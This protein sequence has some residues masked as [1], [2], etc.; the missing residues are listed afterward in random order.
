MGNDGQ[1]LRDAITAHENLIAD[2]RVKLSPVDRKM[3]DLRLASIQL[4][5]VKQ[6]ESG[7]ANTPESPDQ[8][9]AENRRLL[10]VQRYLGEAS[11]IHFFHALESSFGQQPGSKQQDGP[12][13]QEQVDS[14]EQECIRP[15]SPEQNQGFFPQRTVADNLVNIYFST[16]HI[17]YPFISEPDF[18][19]TYENFWQSD[20]LEGFR[21]PW[22]SML[23]TI[24][25]LGSCYERVAEADDGAASNP[26]SSRQDVRY[27]DHAVAISQKQTSKRTAEYV[28]ALLTQCFYLLATCQTDRCWI[29]LG[30]AARIAQSIGLH[31]EEGSSDDDLTDPEGHKK[32]HQQGWVGDYFIAMIKFSGILGRVFHRLYGPKRSDDGV[33]ILSNIDLSDT[34]LLQWRSSLRRELRF[35]LS[36][37]FESSKVFRNQRNMLAVKF[38][39]LR[40]L[41]HRPLLS[42]AKVMA[43]SPNHLAWHQAEHHRISMSKR[44]CVMAAQQTAKLLH[45]LENKKSLIYGFPWWQ[46]ISCL[47]CASSILLVASICVDLNSKTEVEV[48]EDID[49]LAVDEDA[50]VCLQ[51]FQA[52]SSNSNAARLAR[53]MMQRLKKTRTIAYGKM[54]NSLSTASMPAAES[55]IEGVNGDLIAASPSDASMLSQLD[56]GGLSQ[57]SIDLMFQTMPYEVSEPVMCW[58]PTVNSDHQQ[59]KFLW[60]STSPMALSISLYHDEGKQFTPGSLVPGVVKF[61]NYEDQIIESL[62][63]D[64]RGHSNVFLNQNYGDM[65]IPRED[66]GS[67][68]YLFSRHLDLCSGNVVHQKGTHVWPFAFRIPFFAAPRIVSPGS[69]DF[70]RP[71]HPWRGDFALERDRP[72]PLPPS[73]Q[74]KGKFVCNVR[75][76]LDAALAHRRLTAT[77]S[78][79]V[80]SSRSVPV[81]SLEMAPRNSPGGDWVYMTHRQPLRCPRPKLSRR[82]FRRR[83]SNFRQKDQPSEPEAKLCFSVL[84]PKE[85]EVKERQALSV[86]IACTMEH[87]SGLEALKPQMPAQVSDLVVHSFKLSLL[88]HTHVRTGCQTSSS[89]RKIL[90][91]KGACIVPISRTSTSASTGAANSPYS[92]VNL[93]DVVDLSLTRHTL[94][95]DFSTYNIARFHSLEVRFCLIYAGKKNKFTLRN[96]PIRVVPQSGGE[97]ERRLSEG[98][99]ADDEYGCDLAGLQ[100]RG[101]RGSTGRSEYNALGLRSDE[102]D[103]LC[104]G[105]P[106]PAYTV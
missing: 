79:E 105:S 12:A 10:P 106:P 89:T 11:D 63:I 60:F 42:P 38:Y 58:C 51:V 83:F 66:A 4:P 62:K 93:S 69:K 27:F 21:G 74:A 53:D 70:Y 7:A 94:A 44:K 17:A 96:V 1:K 90:T 91:R 8:L 35:D 49:W 88:Q 81:Q 64:F 104:L 55:R 14:Y 68:A 39:N 29:T 34:E 47:I 85:I 67:R 3:I 36:H 97:L 45:N 87:S 19:A 101:Y 72:H 103:D 30:K 82:L 43:S 2:L 23:L 13:S 32:S 6:V 26:H 99:E 86:P 71:T 102:N 65:G 73:I 48:F 40:A 9:L 61:T 25:A 57:D 98:L 80:R 54:M 95:P 18:R 78:T 92:T 22:L 59:E 24:F 50:E 52:L 56:F 84:L 37:T 16:I 28:C 41:I 5:Q 20:S 31:V 76:T 77:K 15:G 100:W 33:L 75:Y 46:M